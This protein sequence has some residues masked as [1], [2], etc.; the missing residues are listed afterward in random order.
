MLNFGDTIKRIEN[1]IGDLTWTGGLFEYQEFRE[2][3]N[4][5][6]KYLPEVY[7]ALEN[8]EYS[9]QQKTIMGLS[10]QGLTLPKFLLFAN[11]TLRLLES[12]NVSRKVFEDVVFPTY[13]WNTKVVENYEN[14]EVTEFLKSVLDSKE[15]GNRRK[16]IVREQILTGKAK[17]YVLDLRQ[18]APPR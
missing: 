14:P 7:N 3:Y 2:I 1:Q 12:G 11:N 13:D 17:S 8:P 18:S 16:E 5:P 6:E 10:M 4:N 9:E 15:V